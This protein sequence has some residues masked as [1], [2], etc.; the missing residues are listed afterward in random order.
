[1]GAS[2]P[3]LAGAAEDIVV[4][5]DLMA[6]PN[7]AALKMPDAAGAEQSFEPA[8][9]GHGAIAATA[10]PTTP[11]S[12]APLAAMD[13]SRP[14]A[15]ATKSSRTTELFSSRRGIALLAPVAAIAIA[16]GIIFLALPRLGVDMP[17][18]RAGGA[19]GQ[20]ANTAAAG[21]GKQGDKVGSQPGDPSSGSHGKNG[22]PG[23]SNSPT[24]GKS[25]GSGKHKKSGQPSPSGK[26]S[27]SVKPSSP[28]KP[29]PSSSPTT[30][31]SPST[32]ASPTPT[33][34][35]T[36]PG[37]GGGLPAGFQWYRVS[38]AAAG[39]RAGFRVAGPSGW[40]LTPG[41]DSVI[42]PAT[43]P[44]KLT[45]AMVNWAVPG[46]VREAKR[47][48]A[49]AR[50]KYPSYQVL[51]ITGM[52][53]RTWP[54]ARW[55]FEWQSA[56]AANPSVVTEILFTVQTWE[57]PQQYILAVSAPEPRVSWA[58]GIL[59]VAKRTFKALP[60]S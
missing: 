18:E 23:P 56:S 38:A 12:A 29:S 42:K 16:A 44:G 27:P 43:G 21:Q 31:A 32:S 36:S 7:F 3:A 60:Q 49:A 33:A 41:T 58:E 4:V 50:D 5:P 14:L 57:G 2:G 1:L 30:S 53:Y 22:K 59:A 35:Q 48:Q 13:V 55:R 11:P 26:P 25:P 54:A 39:T 45:V 46:P 15:P 40:G 24:S 6:T 47:L 51:S 9:L 28:G 20:K 37:S 8:D 10:S 17:F 19:G 52:L 34:T